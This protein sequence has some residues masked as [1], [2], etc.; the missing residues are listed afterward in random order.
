M[1]TS[2][3]GPQTRE[4]EVRSRVTF[5]VRRAE[6]TILAIL[7]VAILGAFALAFFTFALCGR[8]TP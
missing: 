6:S 5:M 1:Q 8:T 4:G 2:P 7:I 3:G